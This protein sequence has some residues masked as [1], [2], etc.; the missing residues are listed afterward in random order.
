ML[1]TLAAH[2]P[3][4]SITLRSG[5]SRDTL[6]ARLAVAFTHLAGS[7]DF[8]LPRVVE[9]FTRKNILAM[10]FIEGTPIR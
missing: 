4:L 1:N 9:E 5:L 6:H 2:L 10:S 3:E 7:S 8:V